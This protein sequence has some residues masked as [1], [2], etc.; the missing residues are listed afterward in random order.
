M[1][2]FL[3][4]MLAL[5]FI[6]TASA[7][8][9]AEETSLKAISCY[10]QVGKLAVKNLTASLKD[11]PVDLQKDITNNIASINEE[12]DYSVAMQTGCNEEFDR[13][14]ARLACYT[15]V[16]KQAAARIVKKNKLSAELS[17]ISECNGILVRKH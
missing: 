2:M 13:G 8:S 17:S 10:E 3:S 14:D 4:F 1:K 16:Y 15:Q 7:S 5:S 6:A 9:S 11:A 12:L